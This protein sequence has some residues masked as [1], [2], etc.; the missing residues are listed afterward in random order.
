MIKICQFSFRKKI[1]NR[2]FTTVNSQQQKWYFVLFLWQLSSSFWP[3]LLNYYNQQKSDITTTI[4][5][6]AHPSLDWKKNDKKDR[7]SFCWLLV[8][9]F[10]FHHHHH[11]SNAFL[12]V[13]VDDNVEKFKHTIKEMMIE[14]SLFYLFS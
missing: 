6:I 7:I 3:H 11:T 14:S 4:I 1:E 5:I 8:I 12:W 2:N 13:C 10:Y 9:W